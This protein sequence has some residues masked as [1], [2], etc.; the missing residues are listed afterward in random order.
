LGLYFNATKK[1]IITRRN[2]I[3][4][5]TPFAIVGLRKGYPIVFLMVMAAIFASGCGRKDSADKKKS[6]GPVPVAVT[7]SVSQNIPW[8]FDT[9]SERN[10]PC[11]RQGN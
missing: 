2:M 7:K 3:L 9:F 10:F 8:I 4:N 5:K 1:F 6:Q 11:W